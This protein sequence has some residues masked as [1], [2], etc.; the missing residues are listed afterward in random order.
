MKKPILI[1]FIL[2]GLQS[3]IA[4]GKYDKLWDEVEK[5]ELEGKFK[6]A[7]EVVDKILKKAERSD[8]GA[9][10]VKSFI[11]KSKFALLL[12]EDAQQ[13]IVL[14]LRAYIDESDFP[15]TAILQS[16]YAG[17][18]EQY[19]SQNRYKIRNRTQTYNSRASDNFE[20]W[21]INA[22]AEKIG[23]L[24]Q[25]SISDEERLK[26]ISIDDFEAILTSSG[27][28]SKYRPTLYDFLAHRALDF[29]K[30][31]RVYTNRPKERFLLNTPI[32]FEPT[33]D[34]AFDKFYTL[35][36]V[37]SNRNAIRFYQKLESLH[38][39]KDTLAYV[40]IVLQRL[41][42]MKNNS[43]VDYKDSL[44]FDALKA[45]GNAYKKHETSAV[46]DYELASFLFEAS[47]KDNAKNNITLKNKRIEAY[48]ICEKAIKK[49][50]N[51]DGGLLCKILKNTIEEKK[52][53]IETEKNVLPQKPFLAKV[54][55]RN[56]DSLYLSM[57]RIPRDYFENSYSYVKDSLSLEI[58]Q[59]QKPVASK[60]FK[61]Q[62]NSDFYEYTTEIDLP[63]IS[64]G[65]YM[66]V[67]S[68]IGKV[69]DLSEIYASDVISV[70]NLALL[71]SQTDGQLNLKFL[72]RQNGKPISGA[73]ITITDGEKINQEGKTDSFGEYHVKRSKKETYDLR[74]TASQE[75]D[76]LLHTDYSL[77][78]RY[79]KDEDE[80]HT[81]KMYL[82]MDRSIYRPGQTLYFKGMVIEKKKG[83]SKVVPKTYVS[84][85]IEDANGEELKEFRLKTNAYGSVNGE[86]KIPKSVLTGEFYI[87][88]EEDY[89]D[90]DGKY[91][92]YWDKVDDYE[93]AEIDF[94]VEEYK[95]PKFE[96]TFNEITENLIIG[97]SISVSGAAKAYL[98]AD[99]SNAKVTYT[100]ER[101]IT[102]LS[103][104]F[105]Y[106]GVKQ[107]IKQGETETDSKGKFSIPFIAIPD[108]TLTKENRPVFSYTVSAEVTDINGET[109]E[110]EKT[111]YAGYHNLTAEITVGKKLN[112]N[113]LNSISV[114]TNNLNDQPI[115]AQV[116]LK[117]Y[118][119]KEPER[120]LRKKPWPV[121][122][123]QSI[124]K[125]IF[126]KLFPNEPYDSTNIKKNWPKD[127]QVFHKSFNTEDTDQLELGDISNWKSGAYTVEITAVDNRKDTVTVHESFEVF[128]PKDNYL[129]NH[130]LF[131]YELV[132]SK[133][134]TDGYV[135]LKFKTAAKEL[136]VF[137]EA[138]YG[139]KEVFKKLIPI[140]DGSTLIKVPV[141]DY[142]KNKLAFNFYYTKFNS[143]YSDQFAVNF[144]EV[145]KALSIETLSF[146]NK[147]IPDSKENW[148]FKITDSNRENAQA[149][150]M[151]A[152]YDTSLDQF[153]EH[154]WNQDIGFRNYN[155]SRA[156]YIKNMGSFDTNSFRPFNYIGKRN[157]LPF[158]KNYHQL[159]WFGLN[160]GRMS[161]ENERYLK[162]L[163]QKAQQSQRINGNISGIVADQDGIPLPGVSIVVKGTTNGTQTDFDGFYSINAPAGSELIFSY[164]GQK[165]EQVAIKKSG[166]VNIV[167]T[168][169]ANKLEEVVIT[170][171][172]VQRQSMLLSS[173]VTYTNA[174]SIYD[175]IERKLQ[176]KVAGVN[177]TQT[178][179]AAGA[180][181]KVII[182]GL[183]S[184]SS[185]N[186]TLFIIDGVPV[187]FANGVSSEVTLL[188]ND[189]ADITVLKDGAAAAIYGSRGANG[190]VVITTKQGL[191]E[192]FQVEP[193]ADLKETAF[194][195]PTLTADKDGTVSFN[196][197]S[198]QALTKWKFMLLAHTKD[199]ELGGLEK[200]VITQKDLSVIPN[201]PRF[202]RERDSITFSAKLSNLTANAL[203]GTAVLQLFDALTMKPINKEVIKSEEVRS[204]NITANG[205]AEVSWRLSIPEGLQA[206]QYKILAKS[207]NV[208][209]GETNVLPVLSNR[210]LLTEAKPL[211]V[212]PGQSREVKFENLVSNNSKTLKNH[213]F[214][215]EYTSNPAWLA[216]KSLPYLMEFPHECA[217]QTFARFYSNALAESIIKK[218]PRIEEVF[219]VWKKNGANESLLEKNEELKSILL[220]ETPWVK[221]AISD[222]DNKA[223]LANLF[224]TEKVRDQQTQSIN[225]LKELQLSS[226][227]FPWFA[228]D[229][230][231]EFITRHI[232]AGFGHLDKLNIQNDNNY[233]IKPILKKAISYLD[234]KFLQAHIDRMEKLSD[235]TNLTLS[236]SA[237][238]YL[239]TR[240]FF[241]ETYPSSKKLKAISKRYLQKG[242]ESWLT[243]S[244]YNKGLM[245]LYLNRL[246]EGETATKILEALE[247]QAVDSEENGMYWKENVSSWYWY[248]APV[249]TQA[250]LI[251]AF[252]E[253]GNNKQI[254]EKL[255]LWLLKNKRANQWETTKAT[256]EAVYAL[257]IQGSDWLSV[258]DNTIIEIGGEKI[259]T[260][261]LESTKKEAGTGYLKIDWPEKEIT[262][263]MSSI[264]VTNKSKVTGFGGVYWQYFEDLDKVSNSENTPLQIKKEMFLKIKTESGEK[265]IPTP[266]SNINL[267]DVV[268][269]RLEISSTDDLEFVH[270]KDLRAS[271]LEPIDVLSEYKWRDGLGY[272]QS[273]KDVATHF[274]FDRLPKGTYI[275]EYDL[276]ANNKGDF[277][278][279]V[280]TIQS[281]YAP[282]FTSR[283]KGTRM[284]IQ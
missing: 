216:I 276:R 76:T 66:I 129:S 207:G 119:L 28:S 143:L 93:E 103:N 281:M 160:F 228:G 180:D 27:T 187:Q 189:I 232:V 112:S 2:L 75:G 217:E 57:Y 13:K 30:I 49:Y 67:A 47:K 37:Y 55:F 174:T 244:L 237:I 225:K 1:L 35:D 116:E 3:I 227:G 259:K 264:K 31:D 236:N 63:A 195:F 278:I 192:A 242:K 283:S 162:G 152:M 108:S 166:S 170:A 97:D 32:L 61:L 256:T 212:R 140:T 273:T 102:S 214:T 245:A 125:N 142:Y 19:L 226:G 58:L 114:A 198:P 190:V 84:I 231:S 24:Y 86:Y 211:W 179:G 203:S 197:S 151:A 56:V 252:S 8:E 134:K 26:E 136:Q 39:N 133:F 223:R 202:L 156:P 268:T 6:S 222:K 40:D 257:L 254:I 186:R 20:V 115:S 238:H 7:A 173:V 111:A 176:G 23:S 218:N 79:E 233:K 50:P 110:A 131:D 52:L 72:N 113:E 73:K 255:K 154:S 77:Y 168:E 270:L 269:V 5:Y 150:V 272:Y 251:E 88:M 204:F 17:F 29:Y 65:R 33:E 215:L 82:F 199:L 258:T 11:Y 130:E 120:I 117:V 181:T 122:E 127:E 261:K 25:K 177:I 165:S 235:T 193:R 183:S 182:R 196:F 185:D 240:S 279:G 213:K 209:D 137:T 250:L 275:F 239:Y 104:S 138:Y 34:F 164:I 274:F 266:S 282:E 230:E 14:E 271:G 265:L 68:S 43:I 248:K 85:L 141:E 62:Q 178:S 220:S 175:D 172:G 163:T 205:N 83:I 277:S 243:Q 107:T 139:D 36:S 121:V 221:D 48:E 241:T 284:K 201:N 124:P 167:M 99:I 51:S 208:S 87:Y 91:D 44:Y 149:E 229:N 263:K 100:V 54:N 249:E 153:R 159:N 94:S 101:N 184:F 146:R 253:V 41:K 15:T 53:S 71:S 106:R 78:R 135:L 128:N 96:I 224:D 81:A 98:G 219:K 95:R 144:P 145:E 105:Y 280:S 169:D 132:N 18:L 123:V 155:N 148:S 60:F 210:I 234:K 90:D 147:L 247:E 12:K 21:D 80:E 161:Y 158:L 74:I 157:I 262:P 126:I 16:V 46:I 171:L 42:F 9:Q 59:T 70:T 69:K 109:Q 92:R 206:V 38:Q 22:L 188:P 45:L 118:K 10:L 267:G 194:F 191:E 200:T 260:K 246:G 89:G 64:I 4:Q